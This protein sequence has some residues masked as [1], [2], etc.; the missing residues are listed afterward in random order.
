[1]FAFVAFFVTLCYHT[2]YASPW[3]FPPL[4][5]YGA[6]MLLRLLKYRIKDAT[7]T[8]VDNQMTIVRPVSYPIYESSIRS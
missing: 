7:I 6:D 4:A 5:L 2:I 8:A 1:M 3:I